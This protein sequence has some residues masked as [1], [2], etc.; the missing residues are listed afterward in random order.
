MTSFDILF[1]CLL[2]LKK[3]DNPS[4]TLSASQSKSVDVVT[5]NEFFKLFWTRLKRK[6]ETPCLEIQAPKKED[7]ARLA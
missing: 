6:R 4:R 1:G 2:I 3:T 7:S 5:T